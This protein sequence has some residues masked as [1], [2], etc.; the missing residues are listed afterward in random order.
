MLFSVDAVFP[1]TIRCFV[2]SHLTASEPLTRIS[3]EPPE[4]SRATVNDLSRPQ[5]VSNKEL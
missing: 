2:D 3:L 4:L 5:I 1:K